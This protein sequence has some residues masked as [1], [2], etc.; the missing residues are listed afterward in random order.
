MDTLLIAVSASGAGGTIFLMSFIVYYGLWHDFRSL[1]RAPRWFISKQLL[2]CGILKMNGKANMIYE[3]SFG[4]NCIVFTALSYIVLGLINFGAGIFSITIFNSIRVGTCQYATETGNRC[5]QSNCSTPCGKPTFLTC[6]VVDCG[7]MRCSADVPAFLRIAGDPTSKSAADNFATLQGS[8][9]V[10]QVCVIWSAGLTTILCLISE[11][12][13]TESRQL[14][15]RQKRVIVKWEK[16]GFTLLR[17]ALI[18]VSVAA[19]GGVH[20]RHGRE[21]DAARCANPH[22]RLPHRQISTA[23]LVRS[24]CPP[25]SLPD[26][27]CG[28]EGRPSPQPMRTRPHLDRPRSIVCSPATLQTSGTCKDKQWNDGG[29]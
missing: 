14:F 6:G 2:G 8:L 5:R 4:E 7:F 28:E 13:R 18:A 9:T 23:S 1:D 24:A 26:R 21:P 17:A 11:E 27:G 12:R 15:G 20:L 22:G 29:G 10:V 25:S 16:H 3:R 19:G